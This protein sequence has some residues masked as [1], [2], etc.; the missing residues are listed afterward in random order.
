[1][2]ILLVILGIVFWFWIINIGWRFCV[3]SIK[4]TIKTSA[5]VKEEWNKV[6]EEWN[7]VKERNKKY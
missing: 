4:N 2:E 5:K 7:K 1:M 3:K 6:K